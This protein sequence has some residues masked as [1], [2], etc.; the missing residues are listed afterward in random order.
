MTFEAWMDIL[1][2]PACASGGQG[3][4]PDPGQLDLWEKSWLVCQ[5]CQR[6]YPI[7]NQIPVL[8]IE[9]GDKHQKTSL[10]DLGTP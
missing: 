8:L 9:E 10:D 2:C 5:D 4:L 1:R 3:E 7:R 6:K